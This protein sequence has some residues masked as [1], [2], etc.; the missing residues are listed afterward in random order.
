MRT[1]K[2]IMETNLHPE[3]EVL[4]DIR[5]LLAIQVTKS[6]FISKKIEDVAYDF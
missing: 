3:L 6:V 1:K 5:Q 4:F 2:E